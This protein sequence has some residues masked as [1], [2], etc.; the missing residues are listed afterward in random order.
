MEIKA[1]S[2]RGHL[3]VPFMVTV[4]G[5]LKLGSSTSRPISGAQTLSHKEKEHQTIVCFLLS[6]FIPFMSTPSGQTT[7]MLLLPVEQQDIQKER[8]S[9]GANPQPLVS[10]P[11]VMSVPDG[12]IKAW[13]TIAGAWFVLFGTFGYLYSFGVYEDFYALEYLSNHTPSSIAWIGSFQ[14]MMPFAL[15]VISGKLFDL[16]HFHAVEA[17]GAVVF[18]FSVFM[19]SLAK[20]LQYYQI[21]LSQGVGMGIGLGFTFVPTVS[22]TVHHFAKRRGLASGVALSGASIGATIFPIMLNHLIPKIG[23]S[24]AVRATGYI[25]LGCLIIGNALMRTRL[26]PRSKRPNA[27]SPDIKSFFTDAAYMWAVLGALLSSVGFYF[28]L[29]YIQLYA[30]QH[31][32]GNNLAFYSIAILNGCSALGR[33]VGNHLA[34]VLGPF[35]M[36]VSCTL[37]TGGT[38]WAVLGVHDSATLVVVSILYGFFSGAWLALAFACLASLARTPDEVGARTGLALALS[39]VGSLSSAPIQGALLTSEFI[40]IRPIAFSASLMFSGAACFAVTRV[41]QSRRLLSQ[42]V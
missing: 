18:A 21:F 41:L 16:G 32:V 29:I 12:G 14:L 25:V 36:L 38:I 27:V 6:E 5:K 20:P 39:S 22:I 11:D 13:T 2:S 3:E 9:N 7:E 30:V 24:S 17:F 42:T 40:W 10:H 1:S 8:Y 34:D 33:V 35:N 4:R 19:L 15:G 31:S 26:P 28:P 23:F 37:I